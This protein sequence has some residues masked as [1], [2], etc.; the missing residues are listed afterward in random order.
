[1]RSIGK[2]LRDGDVIL[3]NHPAAGG[4][5]EKKRSFAFYILCFRK[6]F[7][8]SYCHNTSKIQLIIYFEYELLFV[9]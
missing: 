2:E 4:N 3:T 7:A 6:S 9:P 5:G 8:G 1:M